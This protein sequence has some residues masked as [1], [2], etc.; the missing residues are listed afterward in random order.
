M[1]LKLWLQAKIILALD[2]AF[3]PPSA[4]GLLKPE[5][6]L[7]EEES[8]SVSA[9][10][11]VGERHAS[12][13]ILALVQ[14]ATDGTLYEQEEQRRELL[15]RCESRCLPL[16]LSHCLPVSLA[17]WLPGSRKPVSLARRHL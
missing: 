10:V 4:A 15:V 16:S 5:P 11:A 17:P 3:L 6:R 12:L 9:P 14:L 13:A 1:L 7:V 2:A 8:W